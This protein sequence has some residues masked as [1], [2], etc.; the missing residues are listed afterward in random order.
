M[1]L[2][3]RS[4][5]LND[6][7]VTLIDFNMDLLTDLNVEEFRNKFQ[8]IK[9]SESFSEELAEPIL[10]RIVNA[11]INGNE[12]NININTTGAS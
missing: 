10:R 7:T 3:F 4:R 6:I 9:R 11:N 5:L 12:S 8:I 2:Q 1:L